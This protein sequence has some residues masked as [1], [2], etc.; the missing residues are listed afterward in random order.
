ML[1]SIVTGIT[2][3]YEPVLGSVEVFEELNRTETKI[4]K[5]EP[6]RTE[7]SYKGVKL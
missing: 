1:L 4:L 7:P 3:Q 6:N 5:T 2:T